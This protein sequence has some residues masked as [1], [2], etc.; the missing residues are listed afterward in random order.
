MLNRYT[1]SP[2]PN[3]ITTH[4]LR[5]TVSGRDEIPKRQEVEK[6]QGSPPRR[7]GKPR[8]TDRSF[9]SFGQ[10]DEQAEE[11]EERPGA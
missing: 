6:P 7:E 11:D 9:P 8:T 3:R 2:H 1:T 4:M 5:Q 10:D